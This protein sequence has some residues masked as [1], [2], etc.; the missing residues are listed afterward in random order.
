MVLKSEDGVGEW[1]SRRK[2]VFKSSTCRLN[3]F[4]GVFLGGLT[5]CVC[6]VNTGKLARNCEVVFTGEVFCRKSK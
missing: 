5:T 1:N 4:S 2:G 3:V 6:A